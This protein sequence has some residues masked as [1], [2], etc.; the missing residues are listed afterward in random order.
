MLIDEGEMYAIAER[1][2]SLAQTKMDRLYMPFCDPVP[3]AQIAHPW[4]QFSVSFC[5]GSLRPGFHSADL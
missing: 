5:L 1:R 3:M 4:W 2:T